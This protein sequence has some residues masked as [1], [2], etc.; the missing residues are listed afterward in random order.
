MGVL[1]LVF[2]VFGKGFESGF[3]AAAPMASILSAFAAGM[4]LVWIGICS[5]YFGDAKD[6]GVHKPIRHFF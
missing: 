6:A 2:G 1:A 3:L 4:D 5:P